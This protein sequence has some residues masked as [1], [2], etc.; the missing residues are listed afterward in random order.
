MQLVNASTRAH[1]GFSTYS[2]NA[3]QGVADYWTTQSYAFGFDRGWLAQRSRPRTPLV[4]AAVVSSVIYEFLAAQPHV[5]AS[6]ELRLWFVIMLSP[7]A[8]RIKPSPCSSM[9]ER[10]LRSDLIR[11]Y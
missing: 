1:A 5:N 9:T 7:Y 11:R 4:T 6:K 8:W 3:M 10:P 2:V